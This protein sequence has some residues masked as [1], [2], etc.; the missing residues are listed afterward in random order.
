MDVGNLL[1]RAPT[2]PLTCSQFLFF[3]YLFVFNVNIDVFILPSFLRA[4]KV[5]RSA[6]PKRSVSGPTL[7]PDGRALQIRRIC[8]VSPEPE[9]DCYT[10]PSVA[11]WTGKGR[12]FELH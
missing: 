7:D 11:K 8:L 2:S 4:A 5:T 10:W 3:V 1:H 12:G 6:A 9:A